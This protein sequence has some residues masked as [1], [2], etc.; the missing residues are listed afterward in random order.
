MVCIK[1]T[2]DTEDKKKKKKESIK[3]NE[4]SEMPEWRW[5]VPVLCKYLS[6][7][8]DVKL[9]SCVSVDNLRRTSAWYEPTAGVT[10]YSVTCQIL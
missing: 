4:N 3:I 7:V 8:Q 6:A 10:L 5:Q 2:V 1:H 9:G